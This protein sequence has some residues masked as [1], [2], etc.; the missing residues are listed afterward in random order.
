MKVVTIIAMINEGFALF[1]MPKQ[2]CTS[3][4]GGGVF[5]SNYRQY[6]RMILWFSV[7]PFHAP[8]VR[9]PVTGHKMYS[10]SFEHT[11]A[12]TND[13]RY[14]RAYREYVAQFASTYCKVKCQII[15][16]ETNDSSAGSLF[17]FSFVERNRCAL[18]HF[19]FSGFSFLGSL[20]RLHKESIAIFSF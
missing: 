15:K 9:S 2:L 13:S 17:S 5:E 19:I 16:I 11:H 6:A 3:F 7:F 10:Y 14:Y 12:H 8:N 1:A 4:F 20:S 18:Y